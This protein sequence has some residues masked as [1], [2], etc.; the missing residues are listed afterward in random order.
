VL[1]RPGWRRAIE[2]GLRSSDERTFYLAVRAAMRLGDD[3]YPVLLE[4]LQLDPYASEITWQDAARTV[5]EA[6]FDD[7]LE[8]AL[9]RLSEH[10]PYQGE[11]FPRWLVAILDGL[12][13][14]PGKGWP[15]IREGLSSE[16]TMERRFG[17]D[18][19]RTLAKPWPREA[20]GLLVALAHSDPDEYNRQIAAELLEEHDNP[21]GASTP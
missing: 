7:L 20:V 11:V 19:M 6:G 12:K 21:G 13:R 8:V 16:V 14:F 3:V 18:G 4:R 1:G 15:L 2:D 17:I 5:D 9:T 10:H